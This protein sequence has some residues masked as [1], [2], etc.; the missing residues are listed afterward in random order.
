MKKV[1]SLLA[2]IFI[3]G[4]CLAQQSATTGE[5]NTNKEDVFKVQAENVS[6]HNPTRLDKAIGKKAAENA[7]P[8]ITNK[9]SQKRDLK[10]EKIYGEGTESKKQKTHN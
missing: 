4:V 8:A 5:T 9:V 7:K 6:V 10:P 2:A 1:Y 3:A